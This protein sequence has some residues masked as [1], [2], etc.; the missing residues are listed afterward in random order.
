[1]KKG[2]VWLLFVLTLLSGLALADVTL[3]ESTEGI[4]AVSEEPEGTPEEETITWDFDELVV[5]TTTPL[6]GTF[7]TSL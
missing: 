5:G 7:F 4:P 1:M 3:P 2:L 6:E